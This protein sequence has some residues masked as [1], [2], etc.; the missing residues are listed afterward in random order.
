MNK[1]GNNL[2]YLT[3]NPQEVDN[4]FYCTT[5]GSQVCEPNGVYPVSQDHPEKFNFTLRGRILE[6]YQFVYIVNGEGWFESLSCPKTKVKAVDIMVLFPGER[7]NYRPD[8]NVGWHEYWIGFHADGQAEEIIS[9]LFSRKDPV[10]RLGLDDRLIFIYNTIISLAHFERKGSQEAI[11]GWL[12]ALAHQVYYDKINYDTLH[13]KHNQTVL[14][15]QILIREHLEEHISPNEVAQRLGVSYSLL[16]EQFRTVTGVSMANYSF[17][18]R[19]NKAK[20][21]LSSTNKSIKEISYA[22]GYNSISRFCCFFKEHVGITASEYRANS[23][24]E[25]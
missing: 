24:K 7:H 1:P 20:N 8:E 12:K 23:I 9:K 25:K 6:D 16:R 13:K 14:D 15:A 21:L 11:A 17:Q 19:L 3:W 10:L 18:Q 5:V 2:Y 22:V 4:Q